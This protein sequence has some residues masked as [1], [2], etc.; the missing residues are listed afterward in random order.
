[1]KTKLSQVR[2]FMCAAQW[3][4]ALR[5]AAKFPRLGVHRNAILDAHGAYTNPRFFMQ[6]SK[7]LEA[8]KASG[9]TALVTMY[10]A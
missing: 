5:I 4:D 1:M 10:G 8:L 2:E 6:V 3:Q 7:D 9:R